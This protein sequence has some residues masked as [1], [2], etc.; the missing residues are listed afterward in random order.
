MVFL[1]A[2]KSNIP[3]YLISRGRY[4]NLF[5]TNSMVLVT[6]QKLP[7]AKAN[8]W[9]YNMRYNPSILAREGLLGLRAQCIYLV[10]YIENMRN[11]IRMSENMSFVT[12]SYVCF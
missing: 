5:I 11:D 4:S 3:R 12:L 9:P 2:T 10:S 1:E 8:Y 6:R 7:A